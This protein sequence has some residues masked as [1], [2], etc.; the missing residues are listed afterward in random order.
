MAELISKATIIGSDGPVSQRMDDDPFAGAYGPNILEPPLPIEQLMAV[1][2]K[3]NILPQCIEAY[4]TNID[5]FGH[6]LVP[7]AHAAKHQAENGGLPPEALE[8]KAR[9]EQFFRLAN[10]EMSFVDL[11]RAT[12]TDLEATGNA[13]WEILRDARGEL[14]GIVHI[15]ADAVRLC[16]L[17][18][19]YTSFEYPVLGAD[20]EYEML[21]YRRRFRRFVQI[22]GSRKAYWKEFWDP[23]PIDARTGKVVK[24]TEAEGVALANEMIHWRIYSTGSP[25]GMPR[26][27]G[28]LLSVVGSRAAEEINYQYFDNKSVPPLV[29]LVS[30][31]HLAEGV[32]ERIETYVEEQIKGR[33]NFHKMLILETEAGAGDFMGSTGSSGANSQVKVELKPLTDLIQK[34]ALFMN[35][36]EANRDK[37]RSAFRL[38]PLY[39]GSAK[40]F[41]RAT[42]EEARKTTESQVFGPERQTFDF[43]INNKLLADMRVR[44]WEFWSLAAPAE[45]ADQMTDVI[46]KLGRYMTS[47]EVR[48]VIERV[49]NIDLEEPKPEEQERWDWLDQPLAVYLAKLG[50]MSPEDLDWAMDDVAVDMSDDTEVAQGGAEQFAKWLI[51]VRKWVEKNAGDAGPG[52]ET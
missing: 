41:N 48:E 46:T 21:P 11:R 42:A 40:D 9:I 36:D 22:V 6:S 29:V 27:A 5:G 12:R 32:R 45:N 47:R 49:L 17:D 43:V 44:W 34:D 26:W 51:G 52:H 8:E 37:I 16:R 10:P 1:L 23:R 20:G 30:G 3:S 25:Y 24:D 13:Y 15:P 38:P 35:Y 50:A 28:V 39:V 7:T 14:A 33:S 4:A 19:E 31:G 18:S 2:R